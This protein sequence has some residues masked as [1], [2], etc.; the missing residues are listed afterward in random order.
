MVLGLWCALAGVDA[1]VPQIV[2]AGQLGGGEQFALVHAA[3]RV[4]A[5]GVVPLA[6]ALAAQSQADGGERALQ[7]G[8]ALGGPQLLRL[9][10]FGLGRHRHQ[11]AQF[12][13]RQLLVKAARRGDGGVQLARAHRGRQRVGLL[14]RL[15]GAGAPVHPHRLALLGLVHRGDGVAH[16]A[17]VPGTQGG[18]RHPGQVV[19]VHEVDFSAGEVFQRVVVQLLR[20]ALADHAPEPAALFLRELGFPAR[21]LHLQR[22]ERRFFIRQADDGQRHQLLGARADR[23]DLFVQ[24]LGG[25]AGDGADGGHPARVEHRHGLF[26]RARAVGLHCEPGAP[27]DHFGS[28]MAA[29]EQGLRGGGAAVV[30]VALA[31]PEALHLGGHHIGGRAP[32]HRVEHQGVTTQ[33]T[34]VVH[35]VVGQLAGQGGPV[36]L[37]AQLQQPVVAQAVFPIGAG[38]ARQRGAHLLRAGGLQPG[39]HFPVARQGFEHVAVHAG[40]QGAEL[41]AVVASE[42]FAHLQ[43]GRVGTGLRP[44]KARE[45]QHG[46]N[47]HEPPFHSFLLQAYPFH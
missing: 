21:A 1:A 17:P 18:A 16:S 47:G 33:L 28:E 39:F 41:R 34:V 27:P 22:R 31:Q 15:H 30:G 6:H 26:G 9:Q 10:G 12:L 46:H 45:H 3:R 35:A 43:Q 8:V 24:V 2:L 37:L 20:C 32:V 23:G 44:G 5:D 14:E 42:R 38:V 11:A 25:V 36:V 29:V 40:Q 19:A 7:A 4:Q 13:Q